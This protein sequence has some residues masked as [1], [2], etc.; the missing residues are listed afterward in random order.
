MFLDEATI[1][2]RSGSG[3]KGA[4]SFRREKYIPRGGP[5]GGDGGRGG[6]VYLRASPALSTLGDVARRRVWKASDGKP[7]G[8]NHRKGRDGKDLTIEVPAGTVVR[9]VVPGR[10]P[11]D[12]PLVAELLEAGAVVRVASGGKGGRGNW[13]FATPTFQTPREAEPGEPGEERK[14]YL[15][16]KLLA[17]AGL[18]GLPNAGKSTLLTRL[19]AAR[20]KVADY[21]FTTLAP[22]L[23]V[24]ETEDFER[25]VFADTP[26]LIAGAHEGV[27]LGFRFL[28]HVDRARVLVHLVSVESGELGRMVED[29]ATI[30]RELASYAERLARKPR[31]VVASKADLLD[32]PRGTELVGAFARR[33][34]RE[35]IAVSARTGQGVPELVARVRALLAGPEGPETRGAVPGSP[36][37]P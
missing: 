30:E 15:E 2:V 17:D 18:I 24:H 36:P 7:G 11:S 1:T 34:G 25:I 32:G 4:V 31:V 21:P 3:G 20:P 5:D 10:D 37:G 12:G 13:S 19:S 8:G 6:H 26:G 23:G 27:G 35:V 14:L 29:H 33:I 16:L 9:E 22:Y 28:R